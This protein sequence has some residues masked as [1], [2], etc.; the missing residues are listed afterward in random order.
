MGAQPLVSVCIPCYNGASFIARTLE[1]VLNQELT[2]AIEVVICDNRSTDD[3][4]SVIAAFADPRL[5]LAQN[6]QNLGI[7]RNWQKALSLVRGKYIKLLCA[8]DLIYPDCLARQVAALEAPEHAAAAL[9]VCSSD[10]INAS[11]EILF[12]RTCRFRSGLNRGA[13]VIRKCVRGGTNLIGEPMAGLFRRSAIERAG[14]FESQNPFL[15]DME[16]W[17]C[18]LK[19]GDMYVDQARL[20]A[21]RISGQSL[22]ADIGLKQ[23][24]AFRSFARSM[25]QDPFYQ[26]TDLDR[27]LGGI[28][29]MQWC[30]LRNSFT[31]LQS[32]RDR[33]FRTR[34]STPCPPAGRPSKALLC[35]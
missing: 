5:K 1:S 17:A 16:L 7:A 23:A 33:A 3:T 31:W 21:F 13:D 22:S 30:L 34:R 35:S 10:I 24:A 25:Q 26:I 18:L 27:R 2:G 20:S 8:D 11:D 19:Q 32:C 6:D 4:L 29:S 28:L 15:I 12:R 14:L 9:A